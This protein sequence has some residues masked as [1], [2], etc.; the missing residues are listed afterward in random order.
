MPVLPF[1]QGAKSKARLPLVLGNTGARLH[2]KGG[3]G[4]FFKSYDNRRKLAI[5]C[6]YFNR[7]SSLIIN[8]FGK[9]YLLI[10]QYDKPSFKEYG[11][12]N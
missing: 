12:N 3:H 6:V 4:F 9:I 10:N 8:I 7:A 11:R 1:G 5:S 2:V